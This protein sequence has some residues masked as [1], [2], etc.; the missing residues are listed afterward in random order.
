MNKKKFILCVLTLLFCQAAANLALAKTVKIALVIPMSGNYMGYGNQL[1]AGAAQAAKDL[2]AQGGILGDTLEIIPYNDKCE[3]PMAISIA[4]KLA[5]DESIP[6]VIGHV[7]SAATIAAMEH[8]ASA[9]KLMITAT[10]T[11]PNI[12]AQNI[13]TVF[14]ISGKDETQS[15][16]IAKFIAEQLQLKRIAILHEQDLYGKD[17]ADLVMAKLAQLEI[18]PVLYQSIPRGKKDYTGVIKKFQELATDSVFFAALYPDVGNLAKAMHK[19]QLQI[20]L[21]TGDGIALNSFVTATG[22][23]HAAAAVIMSFGND[24]KSLQQNAKVIAAMRKQHLETNGYSMYAY[25]AVQAIAAAMQA[26]KSTNGKDLAA[27]LHQNTVDTV[28]GL[29]SWDTNGDIIDAEY[30]MYIW[31][32]YGNYQPIANIKK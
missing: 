13:A 19:A 15:Q 28:L 9:N 4:K 29:K 20:P 23:R 11:N 12:T 5:T 7:T 27:W 21:I 18:H 22:N 16:V 32:N 1:L 31:N 25:C 24:G 6:A 3:V 10:A 8:Y 17:L 26:T 2:N 14:R 30:K